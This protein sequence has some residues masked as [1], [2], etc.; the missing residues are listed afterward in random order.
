MNIKN[1]LAIILGIGVLLIGVYLVVNTNSDSSLTRHGAPA[2]MHVMPDGTVMSHDD[3]AMVGHMDMTVGSEREFI[4]GMIPH[5]QEAVD[6]A[7][8]VLERGGVLPQVR[9]LAQN[10]VREQEREI[11]QMK[12]WYEAWYG[13]PYQDVGIYAPMMRDL[14]ELSG[15]EL[16]IVFLEDMIMHHMGVIM[17]AQSVTPHI[18]H[19]EIRILIDAIIETQAVEIQLMQDILVERF[20][21]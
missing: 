7:K 1:R 4:E 13:E 3:M 6:T 21:I 19:E 15:E 18:E 11:T 20:S 10:V 16:D 8:E 2:G 12:V 5:H 14:S 17:M 9:T